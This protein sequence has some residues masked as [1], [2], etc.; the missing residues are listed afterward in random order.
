MQYNCGYEQY[1]SK[2][3]WYLTLSSNKTYYDSILTTKRWRTMSYWNYQNKLIYIL[4][5]YMVIYK[6]MYYITEGIFKLKQILYCG[7]TPLLICYFNHY[8]IH[9]IL[10]HQ[11]TK[12]HFHEFMTQLKNNGKGLLVSL[13]CYAPRWYID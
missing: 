8:F 13:S 1:F 7:K 10:L 9:E 11:C 5:Y 2:N 3:I 12:L 4:F 6:C